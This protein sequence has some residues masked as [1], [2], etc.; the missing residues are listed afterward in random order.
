MSRYKPQPLEK[1]IEKACKKIATAAGALFLK[2]NIPGYPGFPD[3][4]LIVNDETAYV[5]LKRPGGVV[6]KLQGAWHQR[7]RRLGH[8]VYVVYSVDEFKAALGQLTA[9]VAPYVHG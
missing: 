8:C 2:A 4:L 5:E 3:R 1:D 6:S 7:L 9:P